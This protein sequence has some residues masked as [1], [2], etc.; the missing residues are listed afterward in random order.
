[1]SPW[2]MLSNDGQEV[3]AL[4]VMRK[5]M[6]L[7]PLTMQHDL[8]LRLTSLSTWLVNVLQ[9]EPMLQLDP[10]LCVISSVPLEANC[11]ELAADVTLL[12][13]TAHASNTAM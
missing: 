13:C 4:M 5:G 6:Q 1:M 8:P 2:H 3:L 10:D 12:E 9:R 11:L 7:L